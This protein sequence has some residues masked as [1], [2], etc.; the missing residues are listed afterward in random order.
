MEGCLAVSSEGKSGGLALM[1]RFTGFYGQ[2]D[3]NL[4]QLSWDMLRRVKSTIN[5]GWIMGGNFNTIL[6]NS[7]KDR[8]RRK[9]KTSMDDFCDILVELNLTDVKTCNGCFTW[10]NNR[11]G[12]MLVKERL[13]RFVI[14]DEARDIITHIW[15]NEECNSLEKMEL[16]RDKLGPWQYQHYKRLKNNIKG[17]EN[18]ISNL[19]DGPTSERSTSLLKNARGTPAIFTCGRRV[20]EKK[21]SIERLKDT[22]GDW[23]DDKKEICHNSWNYFDNLFKTSIN[24]DD[25]SDL[26]VVPECIN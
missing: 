20:V 8:G 5:E 18:E 10:T 6:N 26:H 24:V 16:I 15:S 1:W 3:P 14:S 7:E 17:L 12:T 4:R 11:E 21:N 2:T 19:K 13:D 9:P 25:E 22:H 23:H